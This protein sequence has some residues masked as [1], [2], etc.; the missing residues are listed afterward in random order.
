[1]NGRVHCR[2]AASL[3]R[4]EL[5]FVKNPLARRRKLIDSL[6]GISEFTSA[7]KKI[8]KCGNS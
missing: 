4:N 7:K 3:L 5:K 1:M 8:I 6:T 2:T